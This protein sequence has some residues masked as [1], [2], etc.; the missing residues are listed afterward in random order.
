MGNNIKNKKIQI[1]FFKAKYGSI[2]SKTIQIVTNSEYSHVELILKDTWYGA[3]INLLKTSGITKV[4]KPVIKPNEWT[5]IDV[6]VTKEQYIE[7]E[8][9]ANNSV[10]AGYAFLSAIRTQFSILDMPTDTSE[11]F[12][13]Q[14]VSYVLKKNHVIKL[15]NK[16]EARYDPGSLYRELNNKIKFTKS[17]NKL[18]TFSKLTHRSFSLEE[19]YLNW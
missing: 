4:V 14:F 17:D 7:I 11:F 16:E 5:I 18:L 13:S 10:G 15:K 2:L 1:A 9:T 8:K 12:C 19:L 6:Y 3:N